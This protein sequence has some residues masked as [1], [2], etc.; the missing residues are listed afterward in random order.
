MTSGGQFKSDHCL[1]KEQAGTLERP[2]CFCLVLVVIIALA[3]VVEP[4]L[5]PGRVR[6]EPEQPAGSEE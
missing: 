6:S 4:A 3:S 2:A 1:K 5:V